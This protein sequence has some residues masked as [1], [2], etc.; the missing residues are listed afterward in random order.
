MANVDRP[1]GFTPIGTLSGSAWQG[2]IEPIQCDATHAAIGV[3]DLIE[4]TADGYPDILTAG[5]TDSGVFGLVVGVHPVGEGWNATTGKF[6]DNSLSAT[7]PTLIGAGTRSLALN[8]A[9]TLMVAT[10]PDLLMIGQEDGDT[11]PLTLAAIG[12]N[13][14]IINP[15]ADATT[16]NSLMEIDSTSVATTATLPLRLLRLHTTAE[17]ELASVDATAPWTDWVVTFANHARSGLAVGI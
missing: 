2:S 16:G 12:S 9:G 8:T 14:D 11:T 13:V 1:R 6:G 4:M 10:A 17:N 3:G 15:G 5:A 7:E